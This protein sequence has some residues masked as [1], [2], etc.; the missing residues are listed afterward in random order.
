MQKLVKKDKLADS[1]GAS[2]ISTCSLVN[3]KK[4]RTQL[5]KM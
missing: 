4:E 5:K 2:Y 1:R 3:R